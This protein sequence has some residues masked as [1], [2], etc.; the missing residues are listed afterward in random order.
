MILSTPI[1]LL[2]KVLSSDSSSAS[3]T[4]LAATRTDPTGGTGVLTVPDRNCGRDNSASKVSPN[5]L[6]LVPYGTNSDGDLF[7]MR[8]SGWTRAVDSSGTLI[9]WVPMGIAQFQCTIGAGT[10]ASGGLG[11]SALYC[12]NISLT[13]GFGANLSS[14]TGL[15]L[16]GAV[17][18]DVMGS[19]LV[20]VQFDLDTGAASMNALYRWL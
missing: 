16:N 12:D 15:D 18:V 11:T 17:L 20:Q 9:E 2:Q 13:W 7:N 19:E 3:F 5:G 8:I 6:L 4:A 1:N 10:G 14:P